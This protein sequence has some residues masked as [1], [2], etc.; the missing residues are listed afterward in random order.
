[1]SP[2][3]TRWGTLF[4]L[5]LTGIIG[6][7]QVG[8][9]A[10]AVPALMSDLGLSLV[11]ASWIVGAYGALGT[12]V[13]LP[14]GL[15][16]SLLPARR[17]LVAGL[18]GIGVGSIA[19]AFTE[20][21]ALL[22]ATRGLEGC[23]FLAVILSAPRLF[24]LITA[25]ADSQ[26]AFAFWGTYMPAGSATMMLA[27]PFL[28][29]AFGWQGLW[30]F[31]GLLPLAYAFVVARLDIP[32]ADDHQSS[33][34]GLFAN[35]REGL[36]TPGPILVAVAFG[37]YT[38]QYFALSSLLP[39]LLVDRLGLSIAAAGAI[40]AGAVLANAVGN[41]VAGVALR[42]GVPLWIVLATGFVTS[43]MLAFGIFNDSM[44]VAAVA[45]LAAGILAITGL[46]PA[47]LFAAMP[48]FAPTSAMLAI[49]LGL[50]TQIGI[51]GQLLGPT[52]LASFVERFG[53]PRAPLFFV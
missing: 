49:A 35:V 45:V 11:F 53:W 36:R 44:P 24:R 5:I 23:G 1:M 17:T 20:S 51:S 41:L 13:G 50:L 12:L 28:I 31:N 21:G 14:A 25:E 43:G 48:V 7:F 29:A 4:L 52:V 33:D 19:G 27:G 26:L 34:Q 32:G 10:V 16:M 38:L 46:I 47:S 9:A 30:V 22:I 15:L 42:L 18:I 6:A 40:S 3:R 8:K 2:S 39:A 37:T